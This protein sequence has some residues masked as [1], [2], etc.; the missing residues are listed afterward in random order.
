M[1]RKFLIIGVLA[2]A[3]LGLIA[4]C[5]CSSK[6]YQLAYTNADKYV[7]GGGEF[8]TDVVSGIDIDWYSGDISI[9]GSAEAETVA[10]YEE[11]NE[12]AEELKLHYYLDGSTLRLKFARSRTVIPPNT[13]KKLTVT[14]PLGKQLVLLKSDNVSG[15][16]EVTDI[17]ATEINLETVS[18]YMTVANCVATDLKIDSVSGAVVIDGCR[19]TNLDAEITSGNVKVLSGSY[20]NLRYDTVSGNIEIK[21]LEQINTV[22]GESTSGTATIFFDTAP[23]KID[24]ENTSG[25]VKLNFNSGIGFSTEYNSVSGTASVAAIDAESGATVSEQNHGKNTEFSYGNGNTYIKVSTV[26]G[27]LIITALV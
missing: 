5:A 26:S 13:V 14:V 2:A 16:L 18:S 12:T 27:N 4:L 15:N 17:A 3:I 20:V 11:S 24:I 6:G 21:E 1:K 22:T 9:K 10:F 23:S 19:A 7:L 25:T 8:A